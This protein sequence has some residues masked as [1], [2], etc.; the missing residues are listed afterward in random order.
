MRESFYHITGH[1]TWFGCGTTGQFTYFIHYAPLEEEWPYVWGGWRGRR[2]GGYIRLVIS[3]YQ[4]QRHKIILGCVK[5]Q[6]NFK[7]EKDVMARQL[8]YP[9]PPGQRGKNFSKKF[10]FLQKKIFSF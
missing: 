1:N 8:R 9:P 4:K 3:K 2:G 6:L 7:G 5:P 10:T